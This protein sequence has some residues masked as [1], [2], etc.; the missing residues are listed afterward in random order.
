ME[1]EDLKKKILQSPLFWAFIAFGL[2]NL[3]YHYFREL[4]FWSDII[5]IIIT[6]L[7]Y[8]VTSQ[9]IS[10][11]KFPLKFS[12]YYPL[13]F[14]V[15]FPILIIFQVHSPSL[16]IKALPN[17]IGV[18][19]Q[20]LAQCLVR[21]LFSL[22]LLF[23][24]YCIINYKEIL[25]FF[26]RLFSTLFNF[27]KKI[28]SKF[29]GLFKKPTFGAIILLIILIF[30]LFNALI[31][32]KIV[33]RES[34]NTINKE[35]RMYLAS[36]YAIN[37]IYI[38][39]LSKTFGFLS[40]ATKPF[41]MV[42]NFLY[43]KGMNKLAPAD[44]ER[45][46]WWFRIREQEF[47]NL[48]MKAMFD[49]NEKNVLPK[50]K[51]DE[52]IKMENEVYSHLLNIPNAKPYDKSLAKEKYFMFV[53]TG[54][55]YSTYFSYLPSEYYDVYKIDY[56]NRQIKHFEN[57]YDVYLKYKDYALKNE[58]E[59]IEFF[60]QNKKF[61]MRDSGL[62]IELLSNILSRLNKQDKLQ[63]EC[64]YYKPLAKSQLFILDYIKANNSRLS[65]T[66]FNELSYYTLAFDNYKKISN[67]CKYSKTYGYYKQYL[68]QLD[69]AK[70]YGYQKGAK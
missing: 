67:K 12:I 62:I 49:W 4:L 23:F 25:N 41:Y 31:F 1:K 69:K 22:I 56:T 16:F 11:K 26:I 9:A 18:F 3:L 53:E 57:I 68:E 51:A 28:S 66:D 7:M 8:M 42:R 46:W 59:S 19:E 44:G 33:V 43:N 47:V 54:Y 37:N 64:I 60:N 21:F 48:Y 29:L 14:I 36:A 52:L 35:A 45:E 27:V 15:T 70:I 58:K 6:Y 30:A 20:T 24:F 50:D 40:P 13:I 38:F 61:A 32:G 10:T 34:K 63:C 17:I 5:S 2:T 65:S 55:R 39:P